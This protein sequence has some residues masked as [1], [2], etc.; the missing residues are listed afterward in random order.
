[1][2]TRE[3]DLPEGLIRDGRFRQKPD[4]SGVGGD[5]R[6]PNHSNFLREGDTYGFSIVSTIRTSACSFFSSNFNPS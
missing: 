2:T 5:L 1:M 4:W 6:Q 3:I